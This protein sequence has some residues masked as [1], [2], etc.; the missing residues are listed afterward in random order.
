MFVLMIDNPLIAAYTNIASVLG[1]LDMN[2]DTAIWIFNNY[3]YLEWNE[4]NKE[5]RIGGLEGNSPYVA[6]LSSPFLE[7][8]VF[9]DGSVERFDEFLYKGYFLLFPI[10]TRKMKVT[11]EESYIHDILVTGRVGIDYRVFDFWRPEF[12]WRSKEV[13]RET[14]IN[15]ID[16]NNPS[17]YNKIIAF[18]KKGSI[19]DHADET[20]TPKVNHADETGTP[21]VNHADEICIPGSD[22]SDVYD[23]FINYIGDIDDVYYV[24]ATGF[25]ILNDHACLL[26][27]CVGNEK[28]TEALGADPSQRE[29]LINK[30]LRL[31]ELSIKL[32]NF[33]MKIWYS[34]REVNDWKERV[35]QK[36]SELKESEE[37]F[38][39]SVPKYSEK[40]KD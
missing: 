35:T 4:D 11:E 33:I 25:Q 12:I 23:R 27:A 37:D 7:T 5:L 22:I 38:W 17:L 15:A 3:S 26:V 31:R 16:Y 36:L 14:V 40:S 21:K 10:E 13:D 18:K 1:V 28:I 9:E 30:A 6:M 24:P 29:D 20:G 8:E 32:R 2:N 19:E 39:R 34:K